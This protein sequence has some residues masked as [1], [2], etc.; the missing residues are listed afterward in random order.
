MENTVSESIQ[1]QGRHCKRHG[2]YEVDF[3]WMIC[4]VCAEEARKQKELLIRKQVRDYDADNWMRTTMERGDIPNRFKDSSFE[5]YQINTG[6]QEKAVKSLIRY[7]SNLRDYTETGRSLI[8]S[9]GVGTGKTHLAISTVRYA[10]TSQKITARYTS[11]D[12]LMLRI[13]ATFRKNADADIDGI[14]D[15]LRRPDLLVIDEIGAQAATDFERL[16]MFQIINARYEDC[17]PNILISNLNIEQLGDCVGDRVIDRLRDNGGAIVLFEWDS[18][19][20]TDHG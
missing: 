2:Y 11:F 17:K 7:A 18:H 10:I 9:G 4:P 20:R 13:K 3:A 6:A 15:E 1:P 5:N 19:R 16:V 12:R 14:V 8:L